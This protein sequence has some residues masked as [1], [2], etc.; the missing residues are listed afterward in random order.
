[1]AV[2]CRTHPIQLGRPDLGRLQSHVMAS[3]VATMQYIEGYTSIPAPHILHYSTEANGALFRGEGFGKDAWYLKPIQTNGSLIPMPICS[4]S[5]VC[6]RFLF[7][8]FRPDMWKKW[9]IW[10]LLLGTDGKRQKQTMKCEK[11]T[12]I[13]NQVSTLLGDGV[14]SKDFTEESFNDFIL[15]NRRRFTGT[16]KRLKWVV[17]EDEC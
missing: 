2:A 8:A 1:M 13:W 17:S 5:P 10:G 4:I 9:A 6:H 7:R 12:E 11:E 3:E 16:S 15:R 14:T